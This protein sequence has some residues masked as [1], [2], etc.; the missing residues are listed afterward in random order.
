MLGC[1]VIKQT[2]LTIT[3]DSIVFSKI[4]QP[5]NHI[6]TDS[7]ILTICSDTPK[8]NIGPNISRRTRTKIEKLLL[9]C[10]PKKI[11]T[12]NLELDILLTDDKPVFYTHRPLPFTERG[13]VDTQIDE[14]IKNGIVEPCSLPYAKSSSRS[15]KKMMVNREFV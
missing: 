4:S 2:N 11:K 12:V 3:P 8:F 7:F 13:I 5:A 1:D 9:A 10:K 15:S 14:W 6:E